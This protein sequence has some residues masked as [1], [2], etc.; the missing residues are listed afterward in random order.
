MGV[1]RVP[2]RVRPVAVSGDSP[3]RS[4][5]QDVENTHRKLAHWL[6]AG[7]TPLMFDQNTNRWWRPQWSTGVRV[8]VDLQTGDP[9]PDPV[10][11]RS[12]REPA[13]DGCNLETGRTRPRRG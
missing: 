6:R 3:T 10:F 8:L 4:S 9:D 12:G 7:R 5:P 1:C 2:W 11:P 13:C